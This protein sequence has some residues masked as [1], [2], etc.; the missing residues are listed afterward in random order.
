M[1]NSIS[2]YVILTID[3][4][5]SSFLRLT[6]DLRIQGSSTNSPAVALSSGLHR[7]M[8]L[9]NLRKED[10]SS[11][12]RLFISSSRDVVGI[13]TSAVNSPDS[14]K[15]LSDHDPRSSKSLGGGPRSAII[16]AKWAGVES[17][18]LGNL[19]LKRCSPSSTVQH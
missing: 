10:F 13:F 11:P 15:K 18:R 8:R 4:Q 6:N 9:K 5:S 12:S 14:S 7:S 16:R 19:S 1:H 2:Q 3:F 17:F